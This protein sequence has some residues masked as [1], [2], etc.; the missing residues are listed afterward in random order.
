[1]QIQH[2]QTENR[3][4]F[5]VPGEEGNPLAQLVYTQQQPNTLIMEH[6]E[7]DP[8][9]RGQNIGFELVSA[10]VE[11]ARQNGKK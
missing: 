8:E 5:I 4:K 11:Y 7:V 10:A 3:G 9:L 2:R 1:M 6:T